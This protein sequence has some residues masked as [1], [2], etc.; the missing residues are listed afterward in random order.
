MKLF[1]KAQLNEET[2]RKTLGFDPKFDPNVV[3]QSS[4]NTINEFLNP[5][6]QSNFFKLNTHIVHEVEEIVMDFKNKINNLDPKNRM[7][8]ESEFKT[9]LNQISF[10]Q[11]HGVNALRTFVNSI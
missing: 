10:T 4:K 11:E 8:A 5:Q 2:M 1:K 9:L 7:V 6:E 3:Q